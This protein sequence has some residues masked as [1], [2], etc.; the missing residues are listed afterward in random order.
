MY[1]KVEELDGTTRYLNLT[2]NSDFEIQKDK[3]I[4]WGVDNRSMDL[5]KTKELKEQLDSLLPNK[6]SKGFE[7]FE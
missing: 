1:I 3:V 4:A 7:K 2:Q 6:T 5:K